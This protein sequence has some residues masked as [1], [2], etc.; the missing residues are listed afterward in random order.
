MIQ[1]LH[2]LPPKRFIPVLF[3]CLGLLVTGCA[4]FQQ[5][6]CGQFEEN[7]KGTDYTTQYQFSESDSRTAARDF[8]NLPRGK[9]VAVHLYKM[10]IDPPRI[11]PCRH[12]TIHKEMY[13]QRT[14]R[15]NQVLEEVREFYADSGALIATKTETVGGQLR[16]SGY[17]TGETLLPI[18]ENAP[19]GK[20]RIVSKI[21]L[22]TKNKSTAKVLAKTGISF[23]VVPRQ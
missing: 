7:R 21:V 4:S 14:I 12:L 13:L 17:Y 9:N 15:A 1:P 2:Q 22:K 20:Y 19:M 16:A 23:E 5:Q 6:T 8:K 11:T 3:A 18:P 10:H